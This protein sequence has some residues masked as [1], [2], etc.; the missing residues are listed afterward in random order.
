MLLAFLCVFLHGTER[1]E[2]PVVVTMDYLYPPSQTMTRRRCPFGF[3]SELASLRDARSQRQGFI[4]LI[5]ILTII[6][7]MALTYVVA[8][9]SRLNMRK[10]RNAQL[11]KSAIAATETGLS[12]GLANMCSSNWGG[13]GSRVTG[14]CSINQAF[15]VTYEHGDPTL[16]PASPEWTNYPYRV[17]IRAVGKA[18]HPEEPEYPAIQKRSWVVQLVPR[19][20]AAEPSDWSR[21]LDYTFFQTVVATSSVEIPVRIVGKCRFQHTLNLAA[22]YPTSNPRQRYMSDLYDMISAGYGDWRPFTG[23]IYFPVSS[24]PLDTI[25]LLVNRLRASITGAWANLPASDL[26]FPQE[27]TSY[28]LYPGGKSYSIPR[29]GSTLENTTLSP[30]PESNPCGIV[31]APGNITIRSNVTIRGSLFC[32]G[33]VRIEGTNIVIGGQP[34]WGIEANVSAE[35]PVIVCKNLNF[36]AG[37]ACQ[38]DGMVGLFGELQAPKTPTLTN[39]RITGRVFATAIKID[40]LSPWE[41]FDWDKALAQFIKEKDSLTGE[42][43]YFPLWLRQYGLDVTPRLV[44]QPPQENRYFH[45]KRSTDPVYV[46]A[47]SDTTSIDS[48]PG[49]RWEVIRELH[50]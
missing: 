33:D 50:D 4:L 20:V 42:N 21:I 2:T 22:K 24:Q 32:N 45:W 37:S 18:W 16:D 48:K 19:A 7:A 1:E 34:I 29:L 30:D 17:T 25:D 5:V 35:L 41:S 6:S 3:S 28:C 38:I 8:S 14:T 44:I 26:T 43:R 23:P 31:Y 47:D 49:L 10:V 13:I 46:P 11:H 39:V 27:P 40:S 15:E 36:K 9:T 12:V